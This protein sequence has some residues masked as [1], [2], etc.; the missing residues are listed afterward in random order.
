MEPIRQE[1][2]LES[3]SNRANRFRKVGQSK[4]VDDHLVSWALDETGTVDATIFEKSKVNAE[5]L[6]RTERM[7]RIRV[8]EA[9]IPDEVLKVHGSAPKSKGEG[10]TRLIYE[11]VNGLNNR[12]CDNEDLEK[13]KEIHDHLEADI[14]A[15]NASNEHGT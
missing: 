10:I 2:I 12:L 15:Y 13:A 4:G 11:N 7:E 1:S 5:E 8:S 14:V 9:G 3:L 6:E